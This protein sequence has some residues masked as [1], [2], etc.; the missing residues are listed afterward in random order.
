MSGFEKFMSMEVIWKGV[1]C[2]NGSLLQ[3][4]YPTSGTLWSTIPCFDTVIYIYYNWQQNYICIYNCSK[5]QIESYNQNL[6]SYLLHACKIIP[7]IWNNIVRCM[8]RSRG[9]MILDKCSF[10]AL[11]SIHEQM[12]FLA[13]QIHALLLEASTHKSALPPNCKH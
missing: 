9:K 5:I 11:Y 12:Q 8:F 3:H 7:F 1:D 4:K 2:S 10:S 6:I 13:A